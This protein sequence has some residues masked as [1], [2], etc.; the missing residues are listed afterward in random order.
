MSGG[1]E[2]KPR[3]PW[4]IPIPAR[5]ALV[6][7]ASLV[8]L[9]TVTGA[10]GRAQ[11][12]PVPTVDY[13][14]DDDG[15]IEIST[16]AQLNAVRHDLNGD[17]TPTNN[18]SAAYAQAFPGGVEQMGC[19]GAD[20]C[21]GYELTAN[22][23]FDT[24]GSGAADAGDAYWNNGAGWTPI[25]GAGSV[26][27]SHR[28][29][30]IMRNPFLATFEG[31]GHT[32][33]NLFIN[34]VRPF[35]GLFGYVGSDSTTGAVG[36]IRNLGLIDVNVAVR[37]YVGGLVG[38]NGGVITNSSVTGRVSM[39]PAQERAGKRL[40][41]SG[42]FMGG[43]VGI[44]EGAI[45]ASHSS[46]RI[47]GQDF[48][49]GLVGENEGAITASHSS[50]RISGQD[51]VGGLVGENE[52]AITASHATGHVS[53]EDTVG[54]LDEENRAV[55]VRQYRHPT[56]QV[57]LELPAG[58][59]DR[60]ETPAACAH[61]EFE[62]ETGLRIGDLQDLGSFLPVPALSGF[63]MHMFIGH[64]LSKGQAALEETEILEVVRIPIQELR[65]RILDDQY[66]HAGMISTV[67]IAWQRGLLPE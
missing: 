58:H 29:F 34:T 39:K 18:G 67:L 30:L 10:H 57:M 65:Q 24:D 51:F 23:D 8:V 54:G 63:R 14:T 25:G 22:L 36:E 35:L 20:G 52:G 13:D 48:V 27:D 61:R 3:V 43:L 2:L 11:D 60:N 42:D 32:V 33:A 4:P 19:P 47:S 56:G 31:N 55:C 41:Q 6:A 28:D 49:G 26:E 1:G 40:A 46:A 38:N 64:N 62:E 44:S 5:R 17:G 66:D 7:I 15:L 16:L 9:V 53:A 45:T 50:A 59:V 12:V 37:N 21:L